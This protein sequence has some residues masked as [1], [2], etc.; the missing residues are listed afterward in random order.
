MCLDL[1]LSTVTVVSLCMYLLPAVNFIAVIHA[2]FLYERCFS[3][4]MYVEK[5]AKTTFVRKI[6]P[7]KVEEIEAAVKIII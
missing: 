2:N 4:Y 5:A 3:T 1:S 7:Y 6:F